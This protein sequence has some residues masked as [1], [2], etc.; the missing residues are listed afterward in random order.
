MKSWILLAALAA[1][2]AGGLM[3]AA[4]STPDHV[5]RPAAPQPGPGQALATFAGGCFWCM[6]PPFEKLEGVVSVTSGYTGGHVPNPSYQEVCEGGT[7]HLEA[8]QIL[9][10]TTRI[11]YDRLLEVFWQN[12][13]P[14]DAW[15][16]FADHGSQYHTAVF[17]HTPAQRGAA[18]ASKA[19][20]AA[21]GVFERPIVTTIRDAAPFYPAEDYHQDYHLKQ[22]ERY[23]NYKDGSGRAGFLKRV[24]GKKD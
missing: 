23:Q 12:I 17:Y 4:K 10:D 20:Q 15:G 21:S 14:T 6:E 3:C 2:G 9:Y 24:W 18:E 19:A 13:D 11:G 16:Q 22:P 1:V 8:V 5:S 7:G